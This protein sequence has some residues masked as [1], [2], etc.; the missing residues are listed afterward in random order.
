MSDTTDF[1]DG[2]RRIRLPDL[3]LP[4][5]RGEG[6]IPLREHRHS[7][8][9][10][11]LDAVVRADDARW[12]GDLAAHAADLRAWDGRVLVVVGAEANADAVTDLGLPFA[13]A[14]DATG[15]V[16]KAAGVDA[17]ALVLADLY[18]EVFATATAGAGQPW[19]S[20]ADV[21]EWLRL[22]AIRC[23]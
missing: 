1:H 23:G 12:L 8:A 7:T 10:V 11:L 4:A 14:R 17:P 19:M 21:E 9:I 3:E 6:R 2:P 15:R 22:M 18:G 16:A 13:V 5:L 20:L